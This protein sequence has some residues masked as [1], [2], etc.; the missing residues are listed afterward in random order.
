MY[1]RQPS[2]SP[3]NKTKMNNCRRTTGRFDISW[4]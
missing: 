3:R 2:F 4:S 1:E